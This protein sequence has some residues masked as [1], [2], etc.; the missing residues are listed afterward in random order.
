MWGLSLSLFFYLFFE[1]DEFSKLESELLKE[2][3]QKINN[4][5]IN[6]QL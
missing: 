6:E 2:L 4:Y 1:I 3:F 5:N